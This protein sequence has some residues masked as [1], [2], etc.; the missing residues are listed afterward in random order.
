MVLQREG[1]RQRVIYKGS[2]RTKV[3]KKGRTTLKEAIKGGFSWKRGEYGSFSIKR[4]NK[5]YQEYSQIFL[6]I[7]GEINTGKISIK[8]RKIWNFF[9]W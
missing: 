7:S 2:L 1:E 9:N 4:G 5:E 6:A 8:N 3:V